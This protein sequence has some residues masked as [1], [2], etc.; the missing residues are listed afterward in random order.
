VASDAD[1]L[2][3]FSLTQYG[4]DDFTLASA[5]TVTSVIWRG[6][7]SGSGTP[8]I[9]DDFTINFYSDAS[10]ADVPDALIQSFVIGDPSSRIDTGLIPPE[11]GHNVFEYVADLGSGINLSSGTTYWMSIYNNTPSNGLE[12]WAWAGNFSVSTGAQT[13]V[14]FDLSIWSPTGGV[15]EETYFQLGAPI[16]IPAAAWLFGSALGLLGWMRR[17]AA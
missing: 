13:T 17:K 5:A 14:S 11:F 15:A 6:W 9:S 2:N 16:P 10:G 12:F 7:Y 3:N 4:A 1:P 8:T